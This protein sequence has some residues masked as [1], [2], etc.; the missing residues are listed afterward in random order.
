M[1]YLLQS[2]VAMVC[3]IICM[4]VGYLGMEPP[5]RYAIFG[6]AAALTLLAV[7]W[8]TLVSNEDPGR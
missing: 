8:V 7:Y 4:L 3:A 6:V 5:A 1:R 2:S